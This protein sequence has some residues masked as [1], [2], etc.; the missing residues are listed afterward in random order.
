MLKTKPNFVIRIFLVS[1]ETKEIEVS[2][3]NVNEVKMLELE[4]LINVLE[5][6]LNLI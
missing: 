6:K 4:E 5:I 3:L 2:T 1:K